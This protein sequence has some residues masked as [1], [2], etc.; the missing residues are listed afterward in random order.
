VV[1]LA[2]RYLLAEK[3]RFL[4]SIAGVAFAVLLVL[5]VA[6]LY[7]GWSE[8]S[9]F[10]NQLPGDLWVAQEGTTDP[11]RSSSYLPAAAAD[12]LGQLD[13]VAAVVPVYSRRVAV[14]SAGPD[15]SMHVM[16][17]VVPSGVPISPDDRARFFPAEGSLIV[18]RVFADDAGLA[19]GDGM[20]LL[21]QAFTI[22]HIVP[23][24]N[25]V[26]AL[27]FANG[28]DASELLG[29]DGYVNFFVLVLEPGATVEQVAATV[30]AALPGS[31]TRTAADYAAT[32]A[33]TV[34]EGFLPVVGA[35]V[36]IGLAIGG[37]VVALTTYTATIEK[38]RDFAVMKALGASAWFVYRVV[39][40]QSVII[41]LSGAVAGAAAAGVVAT[42]V[43]RVVPEFVTDIRRTDA[44]TVLLL[45]VVVSLVAAI[46]PVRRI[47]RI[48]PAMVFRA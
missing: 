18:D 32:M 1:P 2:R 22:E 4:M 29:L 35:L 45:T 9:E 8:S 37:A 23:G 36:A 47:N 34:D 30:E 10:F 28:S 43:G 14:P 16:S 46:V 5:V 42:F 38:A 44:I 31:E 3:I 40:R 25:P 7:R 48:D 33:T 6:S 15:L 20:E 41:G 39:I 17:F 13:G 11:L 12:D 26:F 21:N 19:V 24:G 27:A